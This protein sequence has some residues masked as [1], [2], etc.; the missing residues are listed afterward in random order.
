MLSGFQE[1]MAVLS[2]QIQHLL[3]SSV[4]MR[5]KLENREAVEMELQLITQNAVIDEELITFVAFWPNI[6]KKKK[7]LPLT[8]RY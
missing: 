5:A 6:Q 8:R 7:L 3:D 1:E 2:S 4:S